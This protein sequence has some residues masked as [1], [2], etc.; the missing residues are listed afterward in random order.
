MAASGIILGIVPSV[1]HQ[2]MIGGMLWMIIYLGISYFHKKKK[3]LEIGTEPGAFGIFLE[4]LKS[5]LCYKLAAS[6][7]DPDVD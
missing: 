6:K 5:F 3:I 2:A 4:L 7:S 1:Q